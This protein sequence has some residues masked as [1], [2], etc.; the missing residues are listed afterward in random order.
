MRH[1]GDA[2]DDGAT[3]GNQVDASDDEFRALAATVAAVSWEQ[4]RRARLEASRLTRHPRLR[5]GLTE[6]VLVLTA[7]VF[8]LLTMVVAQ[9][10]NRQL[11][12]TLVGGTQR[13]GSV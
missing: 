6:L 5:L 11:V 4:A 1:R 8:S 7:V 10:G 9:Q 3:A 12:G 13:C 2:R